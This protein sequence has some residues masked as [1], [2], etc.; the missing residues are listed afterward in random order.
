MGLQHCGDIEELNNDP[1]LAFRSIES[2]ANISQDASFAR[3]MFA[4]FSLKAVKTPQS[5][6][7]KYLKIS[8]SVEI[9]KEVSFLE[10]CFKV[11]IDFKK[12][13]RLR[14]CAVLS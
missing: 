1:D 2:L 12:A 10:V 14:A 13:Y 3:R 11:S 9:I 7:F 6:S 5:I 4:Q 8:L